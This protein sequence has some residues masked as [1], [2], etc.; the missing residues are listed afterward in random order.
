MLW[1]AIVNLP[2]YV[3]EGFQVALHLQIELPVMYRF[4]PDISGN[5]GASADAAR[6]CQGSRQPA[7]IPLRGTG[8]YDPRACAFQ[9]LIG[10]SPF[11]PQAGSVTVSK[12]ASFS[13]STGLKTRWHLPL[14]SVSA[15]RVHPLPACPLTPTCTSWAANHKG[16]RQA[17]EILTRSVLAYGCAPHA[18]SGF[19]LAV[20]SIPMRSWTARAYRQ[21]T[22][23]GNRKE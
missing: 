15:E 5:L 22:Y 18:A 4:I 23:G 1:L 13:W 2:G 21:R 8:P 16:R 10:A 6:L 3:G 9:A 14:L 19:S 17:P 11:R 7:A 20:R 12:L